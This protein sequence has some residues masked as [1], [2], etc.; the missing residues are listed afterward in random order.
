M[1]HISENI[2]ISSLPIISKRNGNIKSI[3]SFGLKQIANLTGLT[4]EKLVT[5]VIEQ[6]ILDAIKI[7]PELFLQEINCSEKINKNPS[8]I[9]KLQQI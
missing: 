3:N 4:V 8:I 1:I 5:S 9:E 6:G 7:A 2:G